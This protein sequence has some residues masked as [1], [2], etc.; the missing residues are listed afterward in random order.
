MKTTWKIFLLVLGLLLQ[1]GCKHYD[2]PSIAVEKI[3]KKMAGKYQLKELH[4]V[5]YDAEGKTIQDTTLF[6]ITTFE[7]FEP[8][9]DQDEPFPQLYFDNILLKYSAVMQHFNIVFAPIPSDYS[10]KSV[11]FWDPD[12]YQKRINLW[13]IGPLIKLHLIMNRD[14]LSK[15]EERWWIMGKSNEGDTSSDYFEEWKLQRVK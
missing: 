10:G 15:K 2:R 11:I 3:M 1:G 4:I 13:G 9:Y 7:L 6:N 12:S 5:Q 8:N 14:V